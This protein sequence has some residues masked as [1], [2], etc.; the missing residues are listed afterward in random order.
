M[1]LCSGQAMAAG[2]LAGLWMVRRRRVV[3]MVPLS[4]AFAVVIIRSNA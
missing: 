1:G 3:G 2:L 4:V